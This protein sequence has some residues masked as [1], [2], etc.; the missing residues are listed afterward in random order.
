MPFLLRRLSKRC[1]NWLESIAFPD[2]CVRCGRQAVA[3]SLCVECRDEARSQ[4]LPAFDVPAG[5]AGLHIGVRLSEPVRELVHGL[6]YHGQARNAKL[7]VELSGKISTLPETA[8]LVPV[9]VHSARRRERGYNQARLLADAWSRQSGHVVC[10]CLERFRATGSQTRLGADARRAN[11]E[12][13][14]RVRREFR[15][16]APLILVDDVCTTGATFSA[17]AAVLLHAGALEV[18]GLACAWA[19]GR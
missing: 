6:K 12:A 14:L 1:G 7:L 10:D 3:Q 17:C 4:P 19:P 11:L 15:K 18:H 13:A 5:M 2:V 9:P 16:D 8:V